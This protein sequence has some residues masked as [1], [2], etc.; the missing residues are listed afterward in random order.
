MQDY[1]FETM[2]SEVF[3]GKVIVICATIEE[4]NTYHPGVSGPS[5]VASLKEMRVVE[6]IRICNGRT[7]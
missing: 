3:V 5:Q 4:L 2:R 7:L 1:L 6:H